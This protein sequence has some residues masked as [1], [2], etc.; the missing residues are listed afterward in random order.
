MKETKR[1]YFDNAAT[2]R[3]S[4]EVLD[5]MLPYLKDLYGNPSSVHYYGR[6][7]RIAVE[8]S[9][10]TIARLLNVRPANIIFTSGA[11]ESNNMVIAGCISDLG[12]N[13]I[14]TSPLEHH[15]VLHSGEHY[16][17]QYNISLSYVRFN[18]DGSIDQNDLIKQLQERAEKGN[19]CLVSLMHANNETGQLTDI[20]MI[21]QLCN[22][23]GAVFH[24]D[25]VQTIGHYPLDLQTLGV[26][27]AVG[28][29]HKFHGPKGVGLLYVREGLLLSP[30]IYGGSQ[31]KG[32]R[33]GT[34]NVA[35][36]VG[37]AKALQL[38]YEN[39]HKD[40]LYIS[41]LKDYFSNQ[42][43]ESFPGILINSE[44]FSLYSVL[45]V[46]FPK[47]D[48]TEFLVLNLDQKGICVSGGSACS[49]G[50]S[51]VMKH[52]NRAEQFT[53]VRFSFSK[54]NTIEEINHVMSVLKD[55]L[56]PL[57]ASYTYS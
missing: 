13:H 36:I 10:K 33:A 5:V 30:M 29:A 8:E 3:V 2:S 14:I 34:E 50:D 49:G 47:T 37:M 54:Y 12:C 23:T 11:T 56:E 18:A 27:F 38:C 44:N 9:R 22:Q 28:S 24:S 46:S 42:L 1:I 45:S 19:K 25:C 57:N 16:S 26:D 52:L 35:S 6:T 32:F 51:H 55:V 4:E 43:K 39:F 7:T 17:S 40:Q 41:G 15:A 21:S 20:E 31:E 48:R 53:T